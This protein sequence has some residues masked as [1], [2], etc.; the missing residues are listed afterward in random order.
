MNI[1]A[2][3]RT[4]IDQLYFQQLDGWYS[5]RRYTEIL[6]IKK[7]QILSRYLKDIAYYLRYDVKFKSTLHTS[8]NLL[9][10]N[11]DAFNL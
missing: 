2:Y 8:Q 4:T 1:V 6:Q 7:D 5:M 10:A 11:K 9:L 3:S